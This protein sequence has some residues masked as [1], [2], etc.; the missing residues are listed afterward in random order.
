MASAL[1]TF[2]IPATFVVLWATGFIGAK[3]GAPYA[4]PFT[5]LALRF[6]IVFLIFLVV[7]AGFVRNLP[8][9]VAL[10]HAF[11]VG[12]FIHGAY[13]GGVFYAIDS[14]LS[15]GIA[16]LIVSLQP[17][18][19]ALIARFVLG[20]RFGRVRAFWLMV[21]FLGVGLVISPSLTGQATDAG[22]TFSNIAICLLSALALSVG[23]VYQK[24]FAGN[25]D[26]RV[27]AL[28]QYF[29]AVLFVG[30]LALLFEDRHIE[31]SGTFIFALAWLIVVLSVGAIGLLMYL[32]RHHD[33]G[34]VA[35]LFFLVPAVSALM[36]FWI[37]GEELVLIQYLG[38]GVVML[39]VAMAS[40]RAALW[41]KK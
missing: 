12:V 31:W 18:L 26:L 16:A 10:T 29:G 34:A 24:R 15:A 7:V 14:G 21:G 37:F 33:V 28:G 40:R 20:E 6:G 5:F 22:L 2:L 36:A 8:G 38:M 41:A 13:L 30:L 35:S 32:I 11:V 19:T 17:I 1:R 27:S 23:T 9:T 25:L 39:A 3:L 4:E